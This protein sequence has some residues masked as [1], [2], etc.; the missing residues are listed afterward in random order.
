MEL[1]LPKA[2]SKLAPIQG[3]RLQSLDGIRGV[4][5]GLVLLFHGFVP[6]FRGGWIGVDIFFVLSGFLITTVLLQEYDRNGSISFAEFYK[7]RSLRLAPALFLMSAL[8]IL[9]AAV[10]MPNFSARLRETLEAILY[11]TNWSEAF[12]FKT[13][14]YVGHTW[15]LGIEEDFYLVWP[16]ILLALIFLLAKKPRWY[17]AAAVAS[18]ALLVALWRAG[19]SLEGAR[20]PRLYN[21]FD[22][23][24]DSVFIGCALAFV[25]SRVGF[26]WPIGL[27]GLL[28]MFIFPKWNSPF[29]FMGGYTILALSAALLVAGAA[30]PDTWCSRVLS[31][32]PLVVIGQISYGLYLFHYP[33]Y[34]MVSEQIGRSPWYLN[35]IG[36]SL[37]VALALLSYYYLERPCMALRHKELSLRWTVGLAVLGPISVGLGAIYITYWLLARN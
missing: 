2:S 10:A 16:A 30:R 12:K 5:I 17:L 34:T 18:L 7:R 14:K 21:G 4:A 35:T 9:Y 11:A 19:L 27:A 8:F 37:S 33:I 29:M 31:F 32:A 3:Q 1:G 23:R 22:T 25:V 6:G 26:L 28:A 24:S 20:P 15:S 13:A 36:L